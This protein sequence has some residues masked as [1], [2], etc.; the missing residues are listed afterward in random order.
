MDQ[1]KLRNQWVKAR[2]RENCEDTE[3]VGVDVRFGA[4][5]GGG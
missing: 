3:W 4:G 1:N 2:K 5:W